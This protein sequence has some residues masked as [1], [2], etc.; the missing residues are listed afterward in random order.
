[1]ALYKICTHIPSMIVNNFAKKLK[2]L[3]MSGEIR[4]ITSRNV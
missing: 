1:L 3:S 2:H 4:S